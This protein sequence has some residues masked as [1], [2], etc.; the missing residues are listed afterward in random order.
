MTSDQVT[1]ALGGELDPGLDQADRQR[2]ISRRRDA[3]AHLT[4]LKIEL[5]T[6]SAA[7]ATSRRSSSR[8]ASAS[9]C[10]S[11]TTARARRTCSRRSTSS[12]RCARFAPRDSPTSWR[13]DATG[14]RLGA[15]VTQERPRRGST[16]SSSARARDA[17]SS[18]ARPCGRS[19][20]YFGGF[21]VVVFTPEDLALPRGAPGD[22]R[23]F[24]DRAVF[25]QDAGLSR[26]SAGLREGAEAAQQRAEA[27][28]RRGDA[29]ASTSCSPSTTGSSRRSA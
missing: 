20:G 18:M 4:P 1:L 19:R 28:R 29:D 14:A 17:C 26:S 25:N 6:A 11:A 13:S 16:R 27:G 15:R 3:D 24:L 2:R 21:N 12:R 9:T 22:R 5:L 7:C 8:R 23:R 10:S